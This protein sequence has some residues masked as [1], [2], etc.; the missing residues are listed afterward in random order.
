MEGSAL[1]H[2]GLAL[3]AGP[4]ARGA[5]EIPPAAGGALQVFA[6]RRLWHRGGYQGDVAENRYCLLHPLLIKANEK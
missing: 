4:G 2:P 1:Q 5:P 3:R 6:V